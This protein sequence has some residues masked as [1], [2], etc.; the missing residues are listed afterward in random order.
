MRTGAARVSVGA[1]PIRSCSVQTNKNDIGQGQTPIDECQTTADRS[2]ILKQAS[3]TN[4]L[5]YSHWRSLMPGEESVVFTLP[6]C[7]I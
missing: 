3:F 5:D 1:E 4:E 7:E 6:V 2:G